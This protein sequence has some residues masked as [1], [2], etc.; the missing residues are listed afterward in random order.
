[1]RW[2]LSLTGQHGEGLCGI[3]LHEVVEKHLQK[4]VGSGVFL[5]KGRM[6]GQA[7][8]L[9]GQV[10]RRNSFHP[11]IVGSFLPPS[12]PRFHCSES[13]VCNKTVSLKKNQSHRQAAFVQRC[14]YRINMGCRPRNAVWS[15]I[16][17]LKKTKR[18][19]RLSFNAKMSACAAAPG[20]LLARASPHRPVVWAMEL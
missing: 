18:K 20:P 12:P 9:L 14:N 13:P 2:H 3:N 11:Q 7:P 6:L 15:G 1:M 16:Q 19:T 17:S 4:D 10:L 8:S 5:E